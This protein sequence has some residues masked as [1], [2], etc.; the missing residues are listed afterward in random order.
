MAIS[1]LVRWW[2]GQGA[3]RLEGGEQDQFDDDKE[4]PLFTIYDEEARD[5]DDHY[6][7]SR[8]LFECV[9][10]LVFNLICLFYLYFF[11]RHFD[12][13]TDEPILPSPC[14]LN[15]LL[16]LISIPLLVGVC[17]GAKVWLGKDQI[18]ERERD[19]LKW[20]SKIAVAVGF[21]LCSGGIWGIVA[22]VVREQSL[23]LQLDLGLTTLCAL[24]LL[25]RVTTERA[26]DSTDDDQ[27]EF[28]DEK[29]DVYEFLRETSEVY[30]ECGIPLA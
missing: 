2:N 21:F 3:I 9:L 4:L 1:R 22:F 23:W 28:D 5:G 11:P 19:E 10:A 27:R 15:I 16:L 30:E 7:N 20:W 13:L 26:I 6:T 29:L 12:P 18:D 17:A 14:F 25:I 8:L 24:V